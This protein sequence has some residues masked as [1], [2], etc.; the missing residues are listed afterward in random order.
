MSVTTQR[1]S[2]TALG[3]LNITQYDKFIITTTGAATCTL[4]NGYEGQEVY[5]IMVGDNGDL[6]VSADFETGTFATFADVKDSLKLIWISSLGWTT[7]YNGGI[8]IFS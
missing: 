7:L 8:V 3:S 4:P 1:L 6:V 2:G 5:I